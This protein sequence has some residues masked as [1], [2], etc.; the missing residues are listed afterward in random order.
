MSS[1]LSWGNKKPFES[2]GQNRVCRLGLMFSSCE[3]RLEKKPSCPSEYFKKLKYETG[4]LNAFNF[5][6]LIYCSTF[7]WQYTRSARDLGN[8][9]FRRLGQAHPSPSVVWLKPYTCVSS[10]AEGGE[11]PFQTLP[12]SMHDVLG[13]PQ[14]KS[15]AC[16]PR[17]DGK[18][19]LCHLA[20]MLTWFHKNIWMDWEMAHLGNCWSYTH[21]DLSLEP[22]HTYKNQSWQ[23]T[24]VTLAQER[25]R[26]EN[27]GD[28]L[29]RKSS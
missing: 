26:Q 11:G 19:L 4:R 9:F 7:R 25:Q 10:V 3:I 13:D 17:L 12:R 20:A 23:C 2:Q 18:L 14:P 22:Q 5:Y 16:L 1:L 21:E 6:S 28:L 8:S 27:P 24:P 29:A 15:D